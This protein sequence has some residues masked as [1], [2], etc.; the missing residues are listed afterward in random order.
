MKKT[1]TKIGQ[2]IYHL[3]N[4]IKI[5]GVHG[6]ITGDVTD[7]R[8]NVG[9]HFGQHLNTDTGQVEYVAHNATATYFELS[10]A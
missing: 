9:E 2:E 5:I 4:G 6:N 1:L 10:P 3:K 8:G 7:I